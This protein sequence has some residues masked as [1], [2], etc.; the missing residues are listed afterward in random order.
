MNAGLQLAV[1]RPTDTVWHCACRHPYAGHLEAVCGSSRRTAGLPTD[2]GEPLPAADIP[3]S[4]RCRRQ[5]CRRH[6]ELADRQAVVWLA[7]L[8]LAASMQG[9]RLRTG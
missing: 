5:E 8:L 2:V 1:R 3:W 4:Q 6:Y 7:V 9:H